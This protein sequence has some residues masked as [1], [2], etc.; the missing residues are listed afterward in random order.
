MFPD[1]PMRPAVALFGTLFLLGAAPAA[2]QESLL[3][4]CATVQVT[5]Q[6]A[7]EVPSGVQDQFRY[8]CGQVV[9]AMAAV[10]PTV[11]IALSGGA[12][13]L[14]THTTIGRR[15]GIPR[16]GVTARVNAAF[17][18]APD[19]L[20]GHRPSFDDDG[21][22]RPMGTITL[23]IA[24]LQGD[25]V[26]G[27]YNGL[28]FGR[29]A[30]GFGALDLLGSVSLI[31]GADAIGLSDPVVNVGAGARLGLLRQGLVLPGLSVSGMYRTVLGDI[32]F[33]ELGADPAA[34][35]PAELSAS[36]ST[37]SFRGGVS[38]GILLFDLAAGLGW[39]VYTSDVEFDFRLRCPPDRCPEETTLGTSTGVGGR[40]RTTAWN[41]FG[42]VGLNLFLL[43]LVAEVGYQQP[44]VVV[45]AARLQD[46]GLP[47]QQP[48][49]E[50]LGGG[51]FFVGLGARLTF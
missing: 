48:A 40:L 49:T 30:S 14:G 41:G 21:R 8:L 35:H 11:G 9:G 47:A 25:V 50:E 38:K 42:N 17:A 37:W 6:P 46:A 43:R 44:N 24:S 29:A 23:P 33:G 5:S 32:E 15:L 22:L 2:G 26:M 31:P 3:R 12:H 51:R 7:G 34:G 4:A 45:D 27:V 36:L 1:D 39:D 28:S 13:T 16:V 20:D 18:D 19:L 10:Q